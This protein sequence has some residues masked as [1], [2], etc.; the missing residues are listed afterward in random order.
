MNIA[1]YKIEYLMNPR[2]PAPPVFMQLKPLS[3][4]GYE[5]IVIDER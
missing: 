5:I 2:E 4:M 3:D 1:A